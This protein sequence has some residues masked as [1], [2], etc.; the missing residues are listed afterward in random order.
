[1][2]MLHREDYYDKDTDRKWATDVCIRKNRNGEVWE[3][4]LHFQANIMK[5][6]DTKKESKDDGTY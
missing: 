5:F 1:V 2:I 6:T 4:E 3:V